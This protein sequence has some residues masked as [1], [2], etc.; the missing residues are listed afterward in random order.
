MHTWQ[1]FKDI[2]T[3]LATAFFPVV[4]RQ[5]LFI[6]LS[7]IKQLRC[8]HMI[9]TRTRAYAHSY[10]LLDPLVKRKDYGNYFGGS[11][12]VR[13]IHGMHNQRWQKLP[14]SKVIYHSTQC[15]TNHWEVKVLMSL[16]WRLHLKAMK[17]LDEWQK[18]LWWIECEKVKNYTFL[19]V[20]QFD[21]FNA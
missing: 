5:Y 12:E 17:Q 6:C 3:F 19:S 15:D 8:A 18:V 2:C 4:N 21:M 9:G 10:G 11:W 16:S 13:W 20:L 1:M 7:T 14:W